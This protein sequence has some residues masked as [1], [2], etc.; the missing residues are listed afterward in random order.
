[1][2]VLR[3]R[4]CAIAILDRNLLIKPNLQYIFFSFTYTLLSMNEIVNNKL[5]SKMREQIN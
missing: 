1:M 2:E 4:E 3:E 5:Q